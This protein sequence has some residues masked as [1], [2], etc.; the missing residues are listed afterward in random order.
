M[1]DQNGATIG[2]TLR[3]D[4][5]G[6]AFLHAKVGE[7][8]LAA[9]MV[10][11]VRLGS[12]I[13]NTRRKIGEFDLDFVEVDIF[14]AQN[15]DCNLLIFLGSIAE[16][17]WSDEGFTPFEVFG[18]FF[19]RVERAYPKKD[20]KASAQEQNNESGDEKAVAFFL[21]SHIFRMLF[22]NLESM[23]Y[24]DATSTG[25]WDTKR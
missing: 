19:S 15:P 9:Y 14:I 6:S 10:C 22:F 3:S 20:R 5:I 8:I 4:L 25:N 21:C 24:F 11:A 16:C 18:K 1:G 13:C 2:S 17:L 7:M 12:L 23:W